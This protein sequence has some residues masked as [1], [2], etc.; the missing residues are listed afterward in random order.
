MQAW[1]ANN[2]DA[3]VT[4][5]RFSRRAARLLG[6]MHFHRK[7]QDAE[8][9]FERV[10]RDH[11]LPPSAADGEF[12]C[13]IGQVLPQVKGEDLDFTSLPRHDNLPIAPWDAHPDR[14]LVVDAGKNRIVLSQHRPGEH[15]KFLVFSPGEDN[16][17]ELAP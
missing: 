6:I 5:H 7:P 3:G 12:E 15:A 2:L 10:E 8:I 11:A 4:G 13:D 14:T 9:A 16:V 1:S 17:L